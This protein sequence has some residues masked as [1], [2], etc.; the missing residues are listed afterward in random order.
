MAGQMKR[1]K[2]A[3][4]RL[5]ESKI[6]EM[7]WRAKWIADDSETLLE[8][9]QKLRAAADELEEWHKAGIVMKMKMVDDYAWL[10]TFDA[11]VAKKFGL[12]GRK[13]EDDE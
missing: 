4:K 7:V 8:A 12:Q 3:L 5:S 10:E 2:E 11:T 6:Y 9:A 13:R 1:K